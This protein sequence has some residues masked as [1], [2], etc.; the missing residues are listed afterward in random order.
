MAKFPVLRG[1]LESYDREIK[2]VR[3]RVRGQTGL[4]AALIEGA[5][6]AIA[7]VQL[8]SVDIPLALAAYDLAKGRGRSESAAIAS[9]ETAV[10]VGE[11]SGSRLSQPVILTTFD[12]L[13]SV[14]FG[15]LATYR[16][17]SLNQVRNAW[18]T[19]HSPG[20]VLGALIFSAW[21]PS[22]LGGAIG[23]LWWGLTGQGGE[24]PEDEDW[25]QTVSRNG[26]EGVA[27]LIPG[28]TDLRR[29]I[30]RKETPTPGSL[31][32]FYREVSTALGDTI[33][34]AQGK[35]DALLKAG[36][37]ALRL[38]AL[39]YGLPGDYPLRTIEDVTTEEEETRGGRRGSSRAGGGR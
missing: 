12:S 18:R 21:V 24:P 3:N 27:D 25:W 39:A 36:F 35:E 20:A 28:I 10:R 19:T 30:Q 37:D 15:F 26:L 2:E 29:S 31:G 13:A 7:W 9:A 33:D 5:A 16:F 17:T 8:H 22:M 4:K 1:R 38:W 14:V 32:V 6:K 11:G 34:A 23:L